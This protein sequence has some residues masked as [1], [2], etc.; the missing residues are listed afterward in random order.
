MR[1]K[2]PVT[3]SD[4]HGGFWVVT[5]YEH[6][7]RI[8]QDWRT[9]SS[10]KG[11]GVP[12]VEFVVTPL[13]EVSDPP[14]QQIYKRLI[15]PYFTPAAVREHEAETRAR[16]TR[17]IDEFIA[18]GECEFMSAFA[19]PFPGRLF[20]E[21]FLNAPPDEAEKMNEYS[22]AA[23]TPNNPESP[24]AWRAMFE[25]IADFVEQRRLEPPRGDVVDAVLAAEIDGRP[26]NDAEINGVI[27]LLIL[28]GL[29]T[30]AG[31]LG[32]FMIRF[33]QQPEIPALI[34][35]R[36]EVL[37][38]A[39]EELLR[40]DG[41]FVSVGRLATQDVELDGQQIKEGERVAVLLGVGE[42][43]PTEFDRPDEFD[44]ERVEQ[45]TPGL[46]HR[47]PSL[48]GVEP[49]PHEPGIV[50]GELA[51]VSAPSTPGRSV[52]DPL[53]LRPQPRSARPCRSASPRG[54]D[55]PSA[56]DQRRPRRP[57]VKT[58]AALLMEQPGKWEVVDVEL[59]DPREHEVLV[60]MVAAGLCHSDDHVAKGDGK[61]S[62]LPY[63]G[64]HEAA[65]IIEAVGPGV[66]SLQPGDHIVTSFIPGCGRCRWCAS[67]AQN[68]CD[69]GAMLRDGT[70][71]DGTYRLHHRGRDVAKSSMIGAFAE[72]SVM[73]EWTCIKIP[74][75]SRCGRRAARLRRPDR[76]G[77]GGQRRG[78]ATGDVVIVMGAGGIG[79]NAVQGAAHA[80]ASA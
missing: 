50:V 26:I 52:R 15:N 10:A 29:D 63:C 43:D 54:H 51:T 57:T 9:F 39:V 59:D 62:H 56:R 67:G 77:L 28:G 41:P 64:G 19:R 42:P 72:Y 1:E 18:D 23:V 4:Q 49:G 48:L 61:V 34:R 5:G 73:P 75:T 71:L 35:R 36:P 55:W 79:I 32:Q 17:M 40:L 46:R 76:L 16:V 30:T 20:F 2:C 25:W 14:L 38:D 8:A 37:N 53:P 68:L 22:T 74:T 13:P 11:V 44:L 33:S 24:A 45:P 31:A 27:Q 58:R 12:P 69:N 60:R 21:A 65:G 47:H 70:Q 78:G 6:V 3:H 80:G 66:R 7:M